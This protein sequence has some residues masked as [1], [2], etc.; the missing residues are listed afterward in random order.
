MPVAAE[1]D[2]D[3]VRRDFCGIGEAELSLFYKVLQGCDVVCLIVRLED[4]SS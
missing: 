1:F 2:R 4:D 3:A